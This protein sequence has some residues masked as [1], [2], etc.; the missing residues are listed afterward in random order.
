M[1]Y[2]A[3][4]LRLHVALPGNIL[5]GTCAVGLRGYGTWRHVLLL[6]RTIVKHVYFS[7]Q[8]RSGYGKGGAMKHNFK[9]KSSIGF[10]SG[11][12]CELFFFFF[13]CATFPF[14]KEGF[15]DF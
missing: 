15:S 6:I 7:I 2:V 11:D 9:Q 8:Q 14:V 10:M 5:G 13:K 1:T 12:E 3:T 4:V